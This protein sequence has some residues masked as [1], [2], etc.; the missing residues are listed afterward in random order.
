[1]VLSFNSNFILL[2]YISLIKPFLT[3]WYSFTKS[4]I[5]SR[6][7][8]LFSIFEGWLLTSLLLSE[9]FLMEKLVSSSALISLSFPLSSILLKYRLF[10]NLLILAF[11]FNNSFST[12]LTNDFEYYTL[13]L[14][15]V[16][17]SL[18]PISSFKLK[19]FVSKPLQ[20]ISQ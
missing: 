12:K 2:I 6:S 20:I 9:L 3:K 4:G 17:Q 13:I 7:F 8:I 18:F 19:E 15:N 5:V 16:A 1:M 10:P 11:T 14:I